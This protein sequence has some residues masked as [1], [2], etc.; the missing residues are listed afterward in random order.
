MNTIRKTKQAGK[1][2]S[3]QFF[4]ALVKGPGSFH[5]VTELFA[6]L[7]LPAFLI[8]YLS[9]TVPHQNAVTVILSGGG[10]SS[11]RPTQIQSGVGPQK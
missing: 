10:E 1:V 4:P 7:M 5:L 11:A 9:G 2:I 6:G 8:L 3:R